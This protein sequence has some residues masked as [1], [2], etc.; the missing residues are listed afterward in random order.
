MIGSLVSVECPRGNCLK[1][2]SN[3]VNKRRGEEY[4]E[5]EKTNIPYTR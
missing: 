4:C 1:E 5:D 3:T 2:N